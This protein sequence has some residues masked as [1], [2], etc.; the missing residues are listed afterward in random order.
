MADFKQLSKENH[1][2]VVKM[3]RAFHRHPELGGEEVWTS[4]TIC[5]ELKKMGIPFEVL[6]NRDVI[7][8][9]DT[10]RPGKKV[11]V[12]GDIDALPVKE[13]SGVPFASEIDG[14]MHACGHD[15][16]T[17]NLLGVAKN[18]LAAKAE[19]TGIY[20]LCFQVGEEKAI[21]AKELVA[22]LTA[23][24]GVDHACGIHVFAGA[25]KCVMVPAGPFLA[26]TMAYQIAVTG[27]GGHGSA[28]H[29]AVDPVRPACDI[30]LRISALPVNRLPALD[31]TVISPCTIHAGTAMNIIPDTAEITGT[32]RY[33]KKENG[34][35]IHQMMEDVAKKVA[36]SYGA[37]AELSDLFAPLLPVVNDAA[38]AAAAQAV[39]R[40]LGLPVITDAKLMGSDNF[41]EFTDAFPG[42]YAG[43][44]VGNSKKGMIFEQHNAKFAIDEDA[45]ED[46]CAFLTMSA[47]RLN[48]G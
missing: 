3:R 25:D 30:L 12:R 32:V 5:E 36:E 38:S 48:E 37:Q 4:A 40:E 33:F 42:F 8:I 39:G 21:G 20:Y 19:L 27:R 14:L 44:G 6:E 29:A 10:G 45:L 18:L 34:P 43:F 24:G 46:A 7:G 22:W 28:P 26:G 1:E 15:A 23:H 16:H 35:V 31:S 13:Q 9:F 47:V 11:A 17:A 41:S 2:Y